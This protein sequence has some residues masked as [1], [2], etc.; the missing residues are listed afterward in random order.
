MRAYI[1]AAVAA[2]SCTAAF[3]D[4]DVTSQNQEPQETVSTPAADIR[5]TS[6]PK[7]LESVGGN[8][9]MLLKYRLNEN[10]PEVT[11]ED[12]LQGEADKEAVARLKPGAVQ[13]GTLPRLK[14]IPCDE[15][16]DTDTYRKA[17]QQFLAKYNKAVTSGHFTFRGSMTAKVRW[18]YV[19]E[20]LLK[21]F[22]MRP[23]VF[24]ISF[25]VEGK[26][27]TLS[28]RLRG[29]ENNLDSL[30]SRA[31]GRF[32]LMM[33]SQVGVGVK[34]TPL[35][36]LLPGAEAGSLTEFNEATAGIVK[37]VDSWAG[38]EDARSRLEPMTEAD[39]VLLPAF[40]G[41]LPNEVDPLTEP[42]F[43]SDL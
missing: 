16:C 31:A 25:P 26:L 38:Q 20:G 23:D 30:T 2:L 41:I 10:L 13:V 33:F 24:A 43:F 19:K 5:V 37:A 7:V 35:Q 14:L 36:R 1:L 32:F 21:K 3:A 11:N 6:H 15:G 22:N 18:F 28:T 12:L 8:T 40:D 39:N 29:A 34:P 4:E 17:E 27:L 9:A 42:F